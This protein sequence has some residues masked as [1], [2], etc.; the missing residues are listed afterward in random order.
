MYT[1]LLRTTLVADLYPDGVE[2]PQWIAGV[3]AASLHSET[4]SNTASVIVEIRSSE[5]SIP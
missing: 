2:E 3:E 5:T 1:A 4:V